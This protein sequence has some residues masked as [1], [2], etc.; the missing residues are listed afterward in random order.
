MGPSAATLY[1][2]DAANG[3]IVVTLKHGQA[4][5]ARWNFG[6]DIG[7][8]H[9]PGKYPDAYFRFGHDPQSSAI[10]RCPLVSY[11]CQADSL[12]RF[13]ALNDPNLSIFGRGN[14][15]AVNMGVNGGSERVTYAVDGSYATEDGLIKPPARRHRGG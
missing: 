4:G 14:R 1:G 15:R 6:T 12:V 8:T 10:V 2:A 7:F 5:P 11:A 13:Q 9:Q 3:V